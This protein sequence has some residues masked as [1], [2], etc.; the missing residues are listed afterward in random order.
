MSKGLSPNEVYPE[1]ERFW[2]ACTRRVAIYLESRK[3][4]P[5]AWTL[6]VEAVSEALLEAPRTVGR[7][8]GKA[9]GCFGKLLGS[10]LKLILGIVGVAVGAAIVL[11]PLM[12]AAR[13]S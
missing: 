12:R 7:A 6:A 5:S 4:K 9:V 2:Q 11:P 1:N 13:R 8:T 10:P 3:V